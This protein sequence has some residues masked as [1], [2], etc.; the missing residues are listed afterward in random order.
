MPEVAKI[1]LLTSFR[2]FQMLPHAQSYFPFTNRNRGIGVDSSLLNTQTPS[3]DPVA[4]KTQPTRTSIFLFSGSKLANTRICSG[5]YPH[6]FIWCVYEWYMSVLLVLVDWEC[7]AVC[8]YAWGALGF[9][10]LPDQPP[11]SQLSSEPLRWSS[12]CTPH[13]YC[14]H[15]YIRNEMIKNGQTHEQTLKWNIWDGEHTVQ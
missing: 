15:I 13:F 14:H 12:D 6:L 5:L 3:A 8:R 9:L 4:R 10:F 2:M 1:L 11:S 7:R